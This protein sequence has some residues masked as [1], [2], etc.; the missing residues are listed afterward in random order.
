[1]RFLFLLILIANL[2]VLG[3]GQGFLGNPPSEQGRDAR[4]LLT[5]KNPESIK[6]GTPSDGAQPAASAPPAAPKGKP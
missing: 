3:Y 4:M 5:Q 6:L 1:M 2:I